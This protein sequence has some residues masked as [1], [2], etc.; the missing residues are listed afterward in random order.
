MAVQWEDGS[1]IRLAHSTKSDTQNIN[2]TEA[3][4]VRKDRTMRV[5]FK[6]FK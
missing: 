2:Q 6:K 5:W 3:G 4:I 1:R